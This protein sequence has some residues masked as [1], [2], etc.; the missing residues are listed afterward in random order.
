MSAWCMHCPPPTHT[1]RTPCTHEPHALLPAFARARPYLC[2]F[3]QLRFKCLADG[4]GTVNVKP[5]NPI[6]FNKGTAFAQCAK[7]GVYHLITDHLNMFNQARPP[8]LLI[9]A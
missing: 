9:L 6:S 8:G 1:H 7:C 2:T 3:V 5:I 4:C